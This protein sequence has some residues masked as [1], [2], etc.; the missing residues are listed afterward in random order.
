[1]QS[2][3]TLLPHEYPIKRCSA[4]LHAPA[5]MLTSALWYMWPWCRGTVL[6]QRTT[7]AMSRAVMLVTWQEEHY[8]PHIQRPT[9]QPHACYRRRQ[10]QQAASVPVFTLTGT[11]C[12]YDIS[13]QALPVQARPYGLCHC[14]H[15]VDTAAGISTPCMAGPAVHLLQQLTCQQA[16]RHAARTSTIHAYQVAATVG[17]SHRCGAAC[18]H[19]SLRHDS[20]RVRLASLEGSCGPAERLMHLLAGGVLGDGPAH[21]ASRERKL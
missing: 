18:W 1:M 20:A 11:C 7:A 8:L 2:L 6:A 14:L 10:M 13:F 12:M 21:V 17:R 16:R 15:T 5:W 4:M 19:E 3:S 9:A